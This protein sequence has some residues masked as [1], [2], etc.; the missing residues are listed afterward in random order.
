MKKISAVILALLML[1]S[2]AACGGDG[3]ESTAPEASSSGEPVGET[4]A[5]PSPDDSTDAPDAVI[6]DGISTVFYDSSKDY[7][8]R[9]PYKIVYMTIAN[10]IITQNFSDA[11]DLWGTRLNYDYT[12]Y[13]ANNDT[14]AYINTLEVYASQGIDGYLLDSDTALSSRLIDVCNELELIW[15]PAMTTTRYEDGSLAHPSVTLDSEQFGRDMVTW[16]AEEAT[17]EWGDIDTSKLGFIMLDFTPVA[18]IHSRAIGAEAQFRELFPD[19]ADT[20]YFT[21]DAAVAGTLDAAT[22]STLTSTIMVANPEIEYWLVAGSV[23]DFGQ[24]AARGAESLN[25]QDCTL[26]ITVGGTT[27]ISEWDYG[28][29]SCWK[30]SIFSAQ[31][32]YTEGMAC[33]LITLIDGEATPETLWPEYI[34]PG[35]QYAE[36]VVPGAMLT[37]DIYQEYLEFVDNYTG[38]NLFDYEYNGTQFD[39]KPIPYN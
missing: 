32:L 6:T 3:T 2:I 36:V 17:V 31:M 13:S 23:D 15:M 27:L 25:K 4:S 38:T 30:A 20:N 5:V 21:G 28:N 26:V 8:S 10:S 11:F 29:S 1:F 12:Y 19:I 18:E 7:F 39:V 37:Q 14:D 16:L 34:K 24:G 35:T 22:A 33:G 9:D